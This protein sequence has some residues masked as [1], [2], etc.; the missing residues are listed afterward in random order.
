MGAASTAASA[1]P[2]LKIASALG[3]WWSGTS[4][5][6]IEADSDQNPPITTPMRALPIM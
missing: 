6:A 3:T 5:I 1:L 4:R 2:P